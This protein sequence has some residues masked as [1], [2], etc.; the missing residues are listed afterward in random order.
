MPKFGKDQRNEGFSLKDLNSIKKWQLK[1]NEAKNWQ[2]V[3][4]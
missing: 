3:G 2:I 1:N 4:S